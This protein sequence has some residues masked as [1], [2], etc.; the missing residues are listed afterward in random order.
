VLSRAAAKLPKDEAFTIGPTKLRTL[1]ERTN[2]A[3]LPQDDE[4]GVL[5]GLLGVGRYDV[6][7]PLYKAWI[8]LFE[9][10]FPSTSI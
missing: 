2:L 3:V 6:E 5:E 7:S 1:C 4:L 9:D 8:D 10:L